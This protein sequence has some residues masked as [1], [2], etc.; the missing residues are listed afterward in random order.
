[1]IVDDYPNALARLKI[2]AKN[3]KICDVEIF[4]KKSSETEEGVEA[5]P[6]KK[7]P[8]GNV[9]NK[10]TQTEVD[11]IWKNLGLGNIDITYACCG[12]TLDGTPVLNQDDLINLLINYGFS[13]NSI[14]LFI[15]DY[16]QQAQKTKNSPIIMY[17]ANTAKIMTEVE[18]IVGKK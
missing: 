3:F 2:S 7:K 9:D 18:P 13:M 1:M 14:M 11:L 4:D 6:R 5:M 10:E 12:Y 8:N 17:S 16:A 15:D